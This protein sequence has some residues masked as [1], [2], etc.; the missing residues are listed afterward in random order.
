[1]KPIVLMLFMFF[2]INFAVAGTLIDIPS[3]AFWNQERTAAISFKPSKNKTKIVFYLIQDGQVHFLDVSNVEN[4]NIGKLGTLKS[5]SYDSIN[6]KPI[7]WIHRADGKYQVE[8]QT[9]AWRKGQ[10]FTVKEWVVV[11]K[12]GKVHW[13]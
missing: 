5:V 2:G 3:D 1:M 6:S 12:E 10:R 9:Q 4:Q 8:V 7:A 11:D 13:R